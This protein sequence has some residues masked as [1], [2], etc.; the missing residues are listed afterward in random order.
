MA[1]L[2]EPRAQNIDSVLNPEI[3]YET[4]IDAVLGSL[5]VI[6]QQCSSSIVLGRHLT[7]AVAAHL[8]DRP[9][10]GTTTTHSFPVS[11]KDESL[12][13]GATTS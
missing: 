8:T 11:R 4:R 7:D 1:A 9:Q 12:A 6:R 3:H 10:P 5:S 13:V 2:S